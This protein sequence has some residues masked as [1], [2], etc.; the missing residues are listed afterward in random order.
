VGAV[1]FCLVGAE[2]GLGEGAKD[3]E[4]IGAREVVGEFE[5]VGA[6]EGALVEGVDL[7]GFLVGDCVGSVVVIGD[8]VVGEEVDTAAPEAAVLGLGESKS[9]Q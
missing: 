4:R 7:V 8:V 9:L 5:T 1:V 2:E 3:G 6:S